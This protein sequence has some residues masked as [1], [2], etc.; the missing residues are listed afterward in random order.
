[1]SRIQVPKINPGMKTK[2]F[3]SACL[4]AA[5]TL[6]AQ[7]FQ[8]AK[9][10]GGETNDEGRYISIDASGNIY[11]TG[12]FSGTVDFDP[13]PG[14][15]NLTSSGAGDIFVQKLDASGN[16]LWAKSFG[17]ST[18]FDKGLSIAVDASGNVY[19]T[20]YFTGTADFDP[21]AGTANLTSVGGPDV[22]VQK[23]STTGD[24]IWARSFGG[25]V[26]DNGNTVSVDA[27]GSVYTIGY[28]SGTVDFDPGA[29]TA[30]FTSAGGTDFFIHKLSS[31]GDFL[32][33]RSFGGSA[34]N[35]EGYSL[36][37]DATGNVYTTGIFQGTVDF[38]PGSGTVNLTSSGVRDIF[39][40][41]LN[42]SGNFLWAR[43]FGG[44]LNDFGASIKFNGAS[45]VYVSGNFQGTVDFDPGTGTANLTSGGMRDAFVQKLDTSGNF[46]WAKSFGG[47]S[48]D[49]AN[50]LAADASGN[51]YTIGS[52]LGTV[53]FD[54][55]PGTTNIN[56]FGSNA[57]VFI[58]K[59]DSA[60]NFQW[61]RTLFG[62]TPGNAIEVKEEDHVYTIGSFSG[63]V[64]FD[65]GAG[66]ATLTSA[67]FT[68]VFIQ[69][70]IPSTTGL[71]E[72]V[73]GI[74]FK[75][76]PNPN[77]GLIRLTFEKAL[78]N[79]DITLSDL[80][81]KVVYFKQLDSVDD[82]QINLDFSAGIYFLHVKTSE[83]QSVMRIIK[84]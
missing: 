36:T 72:V 1:M 37:L 70:M 49:L 78:H 81:G 58:H 4:L 59:L 6:H 73:G 19:T 61:V 68:D 45:N 23:L 17:G 48:N 2:L 55:G 50:S 33:A 32:W 5:T 39:V 3:L 75:A 51:V 15:S 74:Q 30:N 56:T 34:G 8:W 20:G 63:Q 12:A 77:K 38:D 43:S 7:T 21:G 31:S 67:G 57:N 26:E 42:A 84:E 18:S 24:F 13:G 46:H 65:P 44:S 82:Q 10:F 16:F 47:S 28:Y 52:F 22:F 54:P 69:K 62:A 80:Q 29:G 40:Q 66:I 71:V 25:S 41:K 64:D 83:G 53:D 79:V 9:S 27:S 11:S 35:D 14:V 60:G 76:F